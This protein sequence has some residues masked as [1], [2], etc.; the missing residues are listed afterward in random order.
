MKISN[1]SILINREEAIS[2]GYETFKRCNP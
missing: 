2:A 1:L